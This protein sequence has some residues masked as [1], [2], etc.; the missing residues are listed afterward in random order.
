MLGS[1]LLA[2][3]KRVF[4]LFSSKSVQFS[5]NF[6]ELDT[7]FFG[8]QPFLVFWESF[9]GLQ[10]FFP[11]NRHF[12]PFGTEGFSFLQIT[13]CNLHIFSLKMLITATTAVTL[14][15][16]LPVFAVLIAIS[17]ALVVSLWAVLATL[18]VRGLVNK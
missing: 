8:I 9:L 2:Q 10:E 1:G 18:I 7:N 12:P 16:L 13:L 15:V 5:S 11:E 4:L 17:S 6:F 14:P 3:S